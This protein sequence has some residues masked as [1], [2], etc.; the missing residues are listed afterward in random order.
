MDLHRLRREAISFFDNSPR[1]VQ[2]LG[3]QFFDSMNTNG[4]RSVDF[5]EIHDFLEGKTFLT[6]L[7]DGELF[8]GLDEDGD[9]SLDF[10]EFITLFYVIFTMFRCNECRNRMVGQPHFTCVVCFTSANS[11]T[12]YDIC[13]SC[14]GRGCVNHRHHQLVNYHAFILDGA[15]GGHGQNTAM[16]SG[17]R[18]RLR[19]GIRGRGRGP[20]RFSQPPGHVSFVN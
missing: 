18:P 9:G 4:D 10:Y 20:P 17:Y 11:N 19:P 1:R 12:T 14:Y 7:L 15:G 8:D 3:H 13:G 16:R 2:I 5:D 6:R